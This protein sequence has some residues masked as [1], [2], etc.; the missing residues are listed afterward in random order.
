MSGRGSEKKKGMGI[1]RCSAQR[2]ASLISLPYR[3]YFDG[4]YTYMHTNK[5]TMTMTMC[6]VLSCVVWNL[7]A[8]FSFLFAILCPM[9]IDD[10]VENQ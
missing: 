10:H 7:N 5:Q 4:T 6:I 1:E 2:T 3:A 8:L 9:M